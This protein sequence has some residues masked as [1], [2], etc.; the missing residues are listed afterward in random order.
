MAS[1]SDSP[2]E[3]APKPR[4]GVTMTRLRWLCCAAVVTIVG[5]AALPVALAGEEE[6][7]PDR[8]KPPRHEEAKPPAPPL[9]EA[10]RPA[11]REREGRPAAEGRRPEGPPRDREG[12]PR[13]EGRRPVEPPREGDDRRPEHKPDMLGDP[14]R[15]GPHG[16][17][18]HPPHGPMGRPMMPGRMPGAMPGPEPDFEAMRNR[19]PE[20][21]KLL[22]KDNELDR[23]TRELGMQFRQAPPE[24]RERIEREIRELV[25]KQF[26]IR[27]ERR[28]IELKRLEAEIQRLREATER[29]A[30]AREQI[31]QRRIS[32]LLGREDDLGF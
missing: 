26:E 29:R 16:P 5:L 17:P 12:R 28:M 3:I 30:K 11:P 20:M 15:P 25:T 32:E 27:Q 24:E 23:L 13:G 9:H 14:D 2:L 18:M 10:D 31:I 7:N 8:P 21:F 6:R 4:G 1:H 19:D 22:Q